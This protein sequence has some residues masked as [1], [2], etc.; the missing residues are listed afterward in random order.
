MNDDKEIRTHCWQH[1]QFHGDQRMKLFNYYL[2]LTAVFYAG[3]TALV[4]ETQVTH[5]LMAAILSAAHCFLS[6]VFYKMDLRHKDFVGFAETGLKAI[7]AK[8]P[9]K[10]TRVFTEEAEFTRAARK[11]APLRGPMR[12]YFTCSDAFRYI[13]KGLCGMSFLFASYFNYAA[14]RPFSGTCPLFKL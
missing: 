13:Y 7:E 10:E 11:H 1:F 6:Y 12:G 9:L 2:L 5:P 14:I 8:F 3:I 4:K